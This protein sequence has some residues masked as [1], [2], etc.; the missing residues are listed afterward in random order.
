[1]LA[2]VI[3]FGHCVLNKAKRSIIM[4]YTGRLKYINFL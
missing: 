1:L 2:I 3:V 4:E